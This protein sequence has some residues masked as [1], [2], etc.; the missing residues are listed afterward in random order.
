MRRRRRRA[1][2]PVLYKISTV[3]D[4]LAFSS[5]HAVPVL[6]KIS[7]VVDLCGESSGSQVPVLYKISTVVDARASLNTHTRVPVLYKISTVVDDKRLS[8]EA[9]SSRSLQNFYCCRFSLLRGAK[10][11][12]PFFTKFLLL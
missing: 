2:V 10:P 1:P 12:F 4:S 3:V 7:T 8:N 5:A 9:A 11:A 6:Y